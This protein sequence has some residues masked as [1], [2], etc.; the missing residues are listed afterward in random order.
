MTSHWH[1]QHRPTRAIPA[2][3]QYMKAENFPVCQLGYAS[4][5]IRAESVIM[6]LQIYHRGL[7]RESHARLTLKVG[8]IPES[9]VLYTGSE[10]PRVNRRLLEVLPF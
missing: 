4:E 6:E 3:E 1:D 10:W 5:A 9:H 8:T 7:G 2:L